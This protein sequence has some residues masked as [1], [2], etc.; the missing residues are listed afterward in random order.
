VRLIKIAAIHYIKFVCIRHHRQV[1]HR[2]DYGRCLSIPAVGW[3]C[4]WDNR[5]CSRYSW[6]L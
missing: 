2:Q 5:W 6:V 4:W 1:F 3:W